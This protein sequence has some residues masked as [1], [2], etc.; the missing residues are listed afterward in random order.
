ML[1]FVYTCASYNGYQLAMRCL[2]LCDVAGTA[3][4]VTKLTWFKYFFNEL[5]DDSFGIE[6]P[7]SA[8]CR[9]LNRLL[10]D[11]RVVFYSY[12]NL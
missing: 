3:G 12:A 8:E 10:S 6:T 2:C 11:S 5:P 4:N 7:S 9:S 1:L